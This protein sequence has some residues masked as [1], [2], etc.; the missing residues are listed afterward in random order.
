MITSSIGS[1]AY[2][3]PI[4]FAAKC[5][6]TRD[7]GRN[8]HVLRQRHATGY[9]RSEW[10]WHG[11][12]D[13]VHSRVRLAFDL[14]PPIAECESHGQAVRTGAASVSQ[15]GT[16]VVLVPIPVLKK[17]KV[18]SEVTDRGNRTDFARR[19]SSGGRRDVRTLDQEKEEDQDEDHRNNGS[20]TGA[21]T[22]T[23]KPNLVLKKG[24]HGRL[25]RRHRLRRQQSTAPSC[26]RRGCWFD[27]GIVTRL[28]VIVHFS[29]QLKPNQPGMHRRSRCISGSDF[30]GTLITVPP[31]P[32]AGRGSGPVETQATKAP[33]SGC[34]RPRPEGVQRVGHDAGAGGGL[35]GDTCSHWSVESSPNSYPPPPLGLFSVTF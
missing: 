14:A 30:P 29:T 17:K 21:A 16:T 25:Q 15:S 2:G 10:L 20:H 23:V 35:L 33:R 8:S 3:Q 5:R 7:S 6:R 28:A 27:A 9:R 32:V 4:T 24:D 1:A 31:R 19:R 18:K 11:D 34:R 22:L 12:A 13:H 26:R